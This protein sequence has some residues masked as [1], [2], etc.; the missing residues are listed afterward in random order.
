M[1]S[2]KKKVQ[3]PSMENK[4]A[5][6]KMVYDRMDPSIKEHALRLKKNADR[7]FAESGAGFNMATVPK[8]ARAFAFYRNEPMSFRHYCPVWG[9]MQAML[10]ELGIVVDDATAQDPVKLLPIW[11]EAEKLLPDGPSK[12]EQW[13]A[14][15]Y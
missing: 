13:A 5:A 11:Q 12:F 8:V 9:V 14:Y 7:A 6:A 15:Y 1:W 3:L 4:I 2:F 10:A